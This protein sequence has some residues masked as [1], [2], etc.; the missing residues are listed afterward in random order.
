MAGISEYNGHGW[1]KIHKKISK[2]SFFNNVDAT[3]LA[4]YLI[5]HACWKNT[6]FAQN[7]HYGVLRRGQC[8]GG[9]NSLSKELNWG[10]MRVRRAL[11][12]LQDA[13][14]LTMYSTNKVAIITITNYNSYQ[15]RVSTQTPENQLG[16]TTDPHVYQAGPSS[17]TGQTP[18][19]YNKEEVKKLRIKTYI[20]CFDELWFMYPQKGR[21]GKKLAKT[22]TE[23]SIKSQE[24]FEACKNAIINYKNSDRV[25][26][27]YVQNGSTFFN[28]W[29]D[30]VTDPDP[31]ENPK[32]KEIKELLEK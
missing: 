13:G 10:K 1:V 2:T 29:R 28:N 25:R 19:L 32:F 31:G 6:E 15:T 16:V 23:A 14:F 26:R 8:L 30:W 17:V 12:R 5:I 3:Y 27:G 7:H 21:V 4:L 20:V 18:S 11:K 22:K 9:Y 24:D